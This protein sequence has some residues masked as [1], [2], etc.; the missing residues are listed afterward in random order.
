M[1]WATLSAIPDAAAPFSVAAR[2][3]SSHHGAST[4]ITLSRKEFGIGRHI[5]N[6]V[7]FDLK[8]IVISNF[9]LKISTDWEQIPEPGGSTCR[10]KAWLT[11]NSTNGTLVNGNLLAKQTRT[12]VI[13]ASTIIE[14]P[15]RN[16]ATKYIFTLQLT[17][18]TA[19]DVAA[20]QALDA[21][22]AAKS[23]TK[24][25]ARAPSPPSPAVPE[26][27]EC[28]RREQAEAQLQAQLA[29][30]EK[31]CNV[32]R[33]AR[34]VQTSAAEEAAET[35]RV[36]A[37]RANEA[38]RSR[39]DA[40]RDRDAFRLAQ[41][42]LEERL[43]SARE[44]AAR[45][46]ARLEEALAQVDAAASGN[47]ASSR[48]VAALKEETARLSR[49]L[50]SKAKEADEAADKCARLQEQ[51]RTERERVGA[52]ESREQ[53]LVAANAS[54]TAEL[55]AKSGEAAEKAAKVQRLTQDVARAAADANAAAQ[56]AS[57]AEAQLAAERA[58]RATEQ[59]DAQSREQALR[60]K[61]EARTSEAHA[62]TSA[63]EALERNAAAKQSEHEALRA[64]AE[65]W[66]AKADRLPAV[67]AELDAAAAQLA[68]ARS[69]AQDAEERLRA[70]LAA[71]EEAQRRGAD[72]EGALEASTRD[73]GHVKSALEDVLFHVVRKHARQT[74]VLDQAAAQACDATGGW[75]EATQMVAP[76]AELD[77]AHAGGGAAARATQVEQ[78]L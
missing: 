78:L 73:W 14:I 48:T 45:L 70:S 31:E 57:E 38:S 10:L 42:T 7:Y 41:D 22:A 12:P 2:V 9:H 19:K 28:A 43:A 8:G 67:Q 40:L 1:G 55:Q 24:K 26:C 39:D 16:S 76:T 44:D 13:A 68:E 27:A 62:K 66:R 11:D 51:L 69:R 54:H 77:L 15:A 74:P 5:S 71:A 6:D 65:A 36:L 52:L 60:D 32:L 18:L 61:L 63:I 53:E 34:A 56:R 46:T 17:S 25:R 47:A 58:R 64:Q 3:A 21:K 50:A 35:A 20:L 30:V 37:A 23:S 75:S 72:A 49:D 33:S 4:A 59:A 29:A